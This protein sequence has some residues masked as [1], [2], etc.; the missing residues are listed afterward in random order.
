M[1]P[2]ERVFQ[3]LQN[4]LWFWLVFLIVNGAINHSKVRLFFFNSYSKSSGLV[5]DVACYRVA[6]TWLKMKA[7]QQITTIDFNSQPSRALFI[8]NAFWRK[9]CHLMEIYLRDFRL[10]SSKDNQRT[11]EGQLKD[12]RGTTKG[13]PKDN[14]R[15]TH[16]DTIL[17]SK[18]F[19]SFFNA[20]PHQIILL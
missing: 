20:G 2:N 18:F 14:R 4:G 19:F 3:G 11:T 16:I 17:I 8:T 5:Q 7:E 9:K 13:Q 1:A 12:N 15:T 10:N 6:C